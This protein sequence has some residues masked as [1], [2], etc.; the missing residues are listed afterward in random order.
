MFIRQLSGFRRSTSATAAIEF[1][2]IAPVLLTMLA[3]VVEVCRLFQVYNATNRL[4]TQYAITWSDCSDQPAGACNTELSSFSS[5]ALSANLV[6]QLQASALT[7][8]MYQVDMN[9]ST[10]TVTYAYPAGATLTAA[11][12]SAATG[13]S[14]QWPSRGCRD[15]DVC[16]Y[17]A[18]L[19]VLMSPYL[20][21][22]LTA[23][24]T[25]VQLK[26]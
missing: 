7:L 23:T 15:C 10:P 22:A 18:V 6:P 3:A 24:Y 19:S 5:S 17:V 20:A 2:F 4:A 1:A 13:N 14:D 25:A 9:G 8:R 11:E 12:I 16:A 26:G 21:S